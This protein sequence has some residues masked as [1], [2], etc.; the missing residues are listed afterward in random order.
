MVRRSQSSNPR[1]TVV[2][3]SGSDWGTRAAGQSRSSGADLPL[4][5][6][7]PA[8]LKALRQT[9]GVI[10]TALNAKRW[11]QARFGL[12]RA[13][14]LVNALPADLTTD[15][16]AQL[17]AL[18]KKFAARNTRA[19]ADARKAKAAALSKRS[20]GNRSAP[21][22]SAKKS[23]T[24][25]SPEKVSPAPVRELGDRLINRAALG[26]GPEAQSR[27]Q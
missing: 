17:T 22:P 19:A 4:P 26:Y 25:K 18:R 14:A 7:Q 10:R 24:R 3:T 23:A 2:L 9:I 20:G 16:R 1:S 12:S 5:R 27:N 13:Q 6:K 8:K 21:K 11:H 15:E